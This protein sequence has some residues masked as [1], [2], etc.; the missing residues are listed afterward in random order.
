M[1]SVPARN[2]K[3][4]RI[5]TL[6]QHGLMLWAVGGLAFG[7]LLATGCR[8]PYKKYYISLISQ[9]YEKTSDVKM[10]EY[11][12]EKLGEHLQGQVQLLGKSIFVDEYSKPKRARK[13][14]KKIGATSVLL[15]ITHSSTHSGTKE[16]LQNLIYD[17]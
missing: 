10:F 17:I 4:K 13:H 1:S 12:P 6:R 11:T 9:E 14:A 7:A 8:N 5:A 16:L 3:T 15:R 2:Q